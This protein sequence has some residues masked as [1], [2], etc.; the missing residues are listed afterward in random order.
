MFRF[1]LLI[2][3]LIS[4]LVSKVSSCEFNVS[5]VTVQIQLFQS[6]CLFGV[7]D[8]ISCNLHLT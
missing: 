2:L 8:H 1:G 3:I 5:T 6:E 7:D 4:T